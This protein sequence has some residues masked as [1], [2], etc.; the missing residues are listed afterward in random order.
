MFYFK[1]TSITGNGKCRDLILLSAVKGC[2]TLLCIGWDVMLHIYECLQAGSSIHCVW[3]DTTRIICM[4]LLDLANNTRIY[5]SRNIISKTALSDSARLVYSVR[6]SQSKVVSLASNPKPGGPR[7]LYLCPS[8][9]TVSWS[10]SPR[11]LWHE[12]SSPARTL[13]SWV[14]I[15][16]EAWLSVFVLF[17]V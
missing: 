17:C 14:R 5:T 16:L 7:S 12:Q 11:G 10:Q 4:R 9:D 6:F 1:R 2:A 8:S 13:G 15:P 3:H